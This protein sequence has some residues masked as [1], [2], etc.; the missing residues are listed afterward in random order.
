MVIGYIGNSGATAHGSSYTSSD[1]S[2]GNSL[3][4]AASMSF[5]AVGQIDEEDC[6]MD[7]A[8]RKKLYADKIVAREG[9]KDSDSNL[10]RLRATPQLTASFKSTAVGN[11]L[12][13]IRSNPFDWHYALPNPSDSASALERAVSGSFDASYSHQANSDT[14]NNYTNEAERTEIISL[15][16]RPSIDAVEWA[17]QSEQ[18]SMPVGLNLRDI[19]SVVKQALE[20]DFLSE[21]K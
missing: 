19:C 14:Q 5:T 9:R 12:H 13:S 16:A 2:S 1:I 3:E 21:T 17:Q 6:E 20:R 18:E 10:E 4:V 7:C 15:G 11:G 8:E